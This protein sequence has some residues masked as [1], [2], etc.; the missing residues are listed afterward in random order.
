MKRKHLMALVLAAHLLPVAA[1]ATVKPLRIVAPELLGLSCTADDICIDDLQRLT[2]ARALLADAT[3]FVARD[4]GELQHRPRAVF[5]ATARC[6]SAFGLGRSVAFS[7]GSVGI[8][9][10]DRAWEPHFVRHELIHQLQ[11]ERLGTLTA[12]LFKPSWLI[13]GMAYARSRDPR[14]PLPQPLQGWRQQY[15]A[16]EQKVGAASVWQAAEHAH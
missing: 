4:L 7:V 9:I 11:N 16:W 13:E 3:A 10:S 2:E 15:Q 14:E 1:W 6:A 8:I 5:C 12:W